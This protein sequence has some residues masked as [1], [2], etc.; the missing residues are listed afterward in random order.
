MW[1][2]SS[3]SPFVGRATIT[4]RHYF[5]RFDLEPKKSDSVAPSPPGGPSYE[6]LGLRPLINCKGTYT[7]ISGS[8][9]LPEVREAM[10]KASTQYVQMEELQFAAGYVA[11][12]KRRGR[13]SQA[14]VALRRHPPQVST[15]LI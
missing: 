13:S 14:S 6:S 9:M 11:T 12:R 15:E 2:V 5:V 7:I 1:F 10:A 3:P 8:L 4:A